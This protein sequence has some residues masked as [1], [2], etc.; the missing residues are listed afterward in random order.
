[1]WKTCWLIIAIIGTNC[2]LAQNGRL[3]TENVLKQE[4]F[5]SIISTM[6]DFPEPGYGYLDSLQISKIVYESDGLEVEGY[7]VMPKHIDKVPVVI[8]NRG[9]NRDYSNIDKQMLLDW[10][11]TIARHGFA[12]FASQYRD[13]DEFG[14]ADINDVLNLIVL[15]KNYP[16]VDSTRLGMVGWSRGGL[17]TYLV[18]TMTDEIDCAILG[19][20]PTDM[21]QMVRERPAIGKLLQKLI[22]DYERNTDEEL[23]KRSPVLWAEQLNKTELLIMHGSFDQRVNASHATSMSQKLKAIEYNHTL[24]IYENDDHILRN[25][26]NLK[27]AETVNWLTEKMNVN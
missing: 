22:P 11:M 14:G 25:N 20:A 12:V 26:R 8:F 2:A 3:I 19:G 21:R 6:G 9:G 17:M 1:M 10:I 27:D 15:A 16:G 4:A 23:Q 5:D 18:L 7:I 24:L 13:A